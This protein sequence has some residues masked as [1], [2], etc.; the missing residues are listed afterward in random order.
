VTRP[1][2]FEDLVG[3]DL[4]AED[5][6][7]L[8]H[9]H[10]LLVEAGPPPELPPSL[11]EAPSRGPAAVPMVLPRRRIGATIALAAAIALV[12]FIGG[13]VIGYSKDSFD[14]SREYP[15]KGTKAAPNASAT[16]K[17]GAADEAGNW[18]MQITV[19]GLPQLQG[20]EYYELFLMRNGKPLVECGRFE[21]KSGSTTIEFTVPY[22]LSR[23]DGWVVTEWKPG[24]SEPGPAL[25]TT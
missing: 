3:A 23:F 16:L 14:A 9:V 21:M 6:E 4:P 13:L 7:R 20:R 10:D 25:L 15:M 11:A 17:L 2:E 1:P 24:L 8:E 12:A 19:R 22:E 5:R 18:P